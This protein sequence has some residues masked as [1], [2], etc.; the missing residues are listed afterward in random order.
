MGRSYVLSF[1]LKIEVGK[2]E[3][4]IVLCKSIVEWVFEKMVRVGWYL[5]CLL[6]MGFV[7]Y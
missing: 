1:I 4:V 2:E 6:R 5:F 7:F 3:E